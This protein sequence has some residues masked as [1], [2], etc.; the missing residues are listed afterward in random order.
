MWKLTPSLAQSLGCIKRFD[1]YS[2]MK[3]NGYL[4]QQS[5]LYPPKHQLS[6][7]FII[8]FYR[9]TEPWYR[10]CPS[11]LGE[12]GFRTSSEGYGSSFAELLLAGRAY[13]TL[14][15]LI[16]IFDLCLYGRLCCV[17]FRAWPLELQ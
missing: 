12:I 14:S 13:L 15:T 4:F 2:S 3:H 9:D 1:E 17:F 7:I 8:T 11:K 10:E 5:Q 6:E 16:L